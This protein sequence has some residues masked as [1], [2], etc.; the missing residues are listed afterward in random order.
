MYAAERNKIPTESNKKAKGADKIAEEVNRKY[1]TTLSGR[2]I[3][4]YV[5]NGRIGVSP[6]KMGPDGGVPEEHFNLLL[7]RVE[8]YIRISQINGETSNNT[9]NKLT[10]RINTTMNHVTT[11]PRLFQRLMRESA[12]D[13]KAAVSNPVEEQRLRWTTFNN[14]NTWHDNWERCL[15]ELGFATKLTGPEGKEIILVADAQKS[16]ILNLDES[17]LTL[18]GNSKQQGG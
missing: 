8:T 14:L 1:N 10:K 11:G 17:A 4:R 16:R 2:T 9:A 18:D 12:I 3:M 6:L 7:T 15:I 5:S 13:F